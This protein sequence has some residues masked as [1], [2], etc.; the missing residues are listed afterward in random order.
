MSSRAAGDIAGLDPDPN[1]ADK[2]GCAS[3]ARRLRSD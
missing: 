1:L 3:R 2:V